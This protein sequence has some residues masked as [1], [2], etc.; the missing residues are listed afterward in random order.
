MA[1]TRPTSQRER[2]RVGS[3]VKRRKAAP[4]PSPTLLSACIRPSGISV[5]A[6]SPAANSDPMAAASAAARNSTTTPRD[7]QSPRPYF[8]CTPK[9]V[10]GKDHANQAS[11]RA[12]GVKGRTTSHNRPAD[13]GACSVRPAPMPLRPSRTLGP[14]VSHLGLSPLGAH[15]HGGPGRSAGGAVT[16]ARLSARPRC[17]TLRAPFVAA[18]VGR[19]DAR[20][21]GRPRAGSELDACR[22]APGGPSGAPRLRARGAASTTARH[23]RSGTPQAPRPAPRRPRRS[24]NSC[25]RSCARS[26]GPATRRRGAVQHRA[27]R[28]CARQGATLLVAADGGECSVTLSARAPM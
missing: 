17:S 23:P 15:R 27:R 4:A 1:T 11:P 16:G 20:P 12:S 22:C 9:R 13:W 21:D 19:L 7:L 28:G 14:A 3:R 2:S 10:R 8:S 6:A 18:R 25:P 5:R 24:R 26:P